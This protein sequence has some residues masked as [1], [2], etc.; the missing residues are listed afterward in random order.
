MNIARERNFIDSSQLGLDFAQLKNQVLRTAPALQET[1]EKKGNETLYDHALRYK[2]IE[3]SP[4]AKDRQ[5]E[6]VAVV[7]EQVERLLGVEVAHS[8]ERQLEQN[9]FVSTVDHHGPICHPFFL[10]ANLIT[11]TPQADFNLE[12]II[13]LSCANVS[14]NNSSF[15]RGLI[16]HSDI[17]NTQELHRL[18]FFPAKDSQRAVYGLEGYTQKD[19]TRIKK[20][21]KHKVLDGLIRHETVEKIT[22]LIDVVYGQSDVLESKNYS[23]Q[24]TKTNFRFWQQLFAPYKKLPN[25][26]YIDQE[27]ITSNLL[28]KYHLNQNTIVNQIIFNAKYQ[29]LLIKYFEGI[30]GAFSKND[31]G[32]FL[33]WAKP[34][35]EKYRQRLWKKNGGLINADGTF[36]VPLTALVISEKLQSGELVPSMLLTFILISFYYGV[37]CLGGFSQPSYLTAMKAG[38]LQLLQEI[39]ESEEAG[40]C[41]QIETK[42]MG[43]DIA[44][45]FLQDKNGSLFQATGLDL[46]LYGTNSTWNKIVESAKGMSLQNGV[47]SMM[48]LFY[49]VMYPENKRDKKLQNI[50]VDQIA[51]LEGFNNKVKP[52]IEL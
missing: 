25:L 29:Q 22:R 32:T 36:C 8:V 20:M 30:I 48:P 40:M 34:K 5:A 39:G 24:I 17:G 19:L 38:Y 47:D 1:L 2:E 6:F 27:T 52:C 42:I 11:A 16:F 13:V 45:A 43:G 50:T 49:E 33:F 10:N 35:G 31:I 21:L 14:L 26:V 12:N 18:S 37:T 7:V 9:Y 51:Q 23:E 4:A 44:L 28:I 41:K 46:M 3:K 15:P